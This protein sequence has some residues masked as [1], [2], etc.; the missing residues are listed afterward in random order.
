MTISLGSPANAPSLAV[1]DDEGTVRV[2][3]RPD[4]PKPQRSTAG[5]SA[6]L[7]NTVA[8]V[9]DALVW[10]PDGPRV[11]ALAI[12]G[13]PAVAD[14]IAAL[15]RLADVAALHSKRAWQDGIAVVCDRCNVAWPCKEAEILG[16]Q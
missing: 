6:D 5:D 15:G 1:S 13:Q 2:S 4:V 3:A 16:L 7:L 12:L 11:A 14:G 9:I 10:R 8:A